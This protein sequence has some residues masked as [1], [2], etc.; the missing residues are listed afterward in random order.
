MPVTLPFIID[1][2]ILREI[3]GIKPEGNGLEA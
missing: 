1:G 3:L 2:E